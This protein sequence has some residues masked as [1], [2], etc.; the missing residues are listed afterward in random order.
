MK[1]MRKEISVNKHLIKCLVQM[2]LVDLI[3]H[4][5]AFAHRSF[6]L[7]YIAL[8]VVILLTLLYFALLFRSPCSHTRFFL[9]EIKDNSIQN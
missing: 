8:F 6:I 3:L 9:L 2:L 4:K 5:N 1:Y 7:S